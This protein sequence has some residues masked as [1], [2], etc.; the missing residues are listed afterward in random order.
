[1]LEQE[2]IAPGECAARHRR[3]PSSRPAGDRGGGPDEDLPDGR[4]HRA[5]AARRHLHGRARRTGGDHGAVRFGQEHAD[6]HPRLP[7][8]A[9]ERQ[10]QDRG[11]RCQ[12]HERF[13]ACLGPQPQDRFRLPVVQPPAEADGVGEC[14]ITDA[15]R[16]TPGSAQ[17]RDRRA[18]GGRPRNAP[19]PQRRKNSR[20]VSSS[21]SPSRARSSTTR[22]S[23]WPTSQPGTSTPARAWR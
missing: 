23:S 15:L 9:D 1:M 18:G 12:P 21:V 17:A 16:R 4:H 19:R 13:A 2:T 14:R 8:Q 7:R 3:R 20:A 6:E 11:G 22:R 10:L 5:R